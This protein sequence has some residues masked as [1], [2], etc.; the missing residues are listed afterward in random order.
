MPLG[1][2]YNEFHASMRYRVK[3]SQKNVCV[4]GRVGWAGG[5][6]GWG[7]GSDSQLHAVQA[8]GPE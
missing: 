1:G 5:V 7:G 3:L 4:Y 6:L 8:E 2:I